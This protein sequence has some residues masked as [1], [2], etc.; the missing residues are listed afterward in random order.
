MKG[1]HSFP[2]KVRR[3]GMRIFQAPERNSLPVAE[4]SEHDLSVSDADLL[5][6]HLEGDPVAFAAIINRHRRE[7]FNFLV[8]FLGDPALAEDVFQEAFLQLYLSA[9]TFDQE[10]RLKPWLF[11]IAT[12]KARDALRSR[13]R[14][15][16][17]PLD[18]TVAGSEDDRGTYADL[19]PSNIPSPQEDAQNQETRQAVQR[20]VNEMPENLRAVLLLAYFHELPYKDVADILD[21]PLGT[22]KSR[23]HAAVKYFAEQWKAAAQ[24]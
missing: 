19:M 7:L 9:A 10:R 17:A 4:P 12:N 11:T 16:T 13:T 1:L 24:R 2:R 22:V 20:I 14:R 18:A 23:L 21:L 5:R 3:G 8:R 6:R 15:Q